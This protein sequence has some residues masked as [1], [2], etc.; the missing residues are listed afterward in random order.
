[1]QATTRLEEQEARAGG[2]GG[3]WQWRRNETVASWRGRLGPDS[4]GRS[5]L[6]RKTTG[7]HGVARPSHHGFGRAPMPPPSAGGKHGGWKRRSGGTHTTVRGCECA[8]D[9]RRS[10]M[11]RDVGVGARKAGHNQPLNRVIRA[12][13]KERREARGAG[14]GAEGSQ[15]GPPGRATSPIPKAPGHQAS[16]GTERAMG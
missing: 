15:V 8:N 13:S 2:W 12:S 4:S 16:D 9:L 3:W 1:M 5:V 6:V 10:G 14:A 11:A 7:G